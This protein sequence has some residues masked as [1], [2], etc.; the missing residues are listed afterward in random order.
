[1]T[2][3]KRPYPSQDRDS[4]VDEA[5]APAF[6]MALRSVSERKKCNDFDTNNLT[7]LPAIY[8]ET[9]PVCGNH[10]LL[11]FEARSRNF[12]K[13]QHVIALDYDV[14]GKGV[15]LGK[16]SDLLTKYKFPVTSDNRREVLVCHDMVNQNDCSKKYSDDYRFVHWAV[17]DYFCYFGPN[18]VNVPPPGWINAAHRHGVPI[19]GT[20]IARH[21]ELME[22]ALSK[23]DVIVDALVNLC[24][25]FGFEGWLINVGCIVQPK[26][27]EK[28][29][30]FLRQLRVAIK[31]EIPH[32]RIFWYD[33]VTNNGEFSLQNELNK[34]NITFHRCTGSTLIHYDWNDAS[35]ETTAATLQRERTTM[36]S[37]FFSFDINGQ[38][39]MGRIRNPAELMELI[40]D[41]CFSTAIVAPNWS[42]Q[43]S[44]GGDNGNG[45]GCE[46]AAF[47]KH[48]DHCW[49]RLWEYLGTR[50]Y[51]K[52]PFYTNFCVGSGRVSYQ[53]GFK[54]LN[55]RGSSN[56]NVQ[57]LQPS[58][59]LSGNAEYCFKE[60]FAG[61][62]S[63]RITN[64]D[65]AFRLFLTEFCLPQGVMVLGYAYKAP[66]G[67]TLDVIMRFCA[68]RGHDRDLYLFC[69]N[70]TQ[71][72]IAGGRC[73]IAPLSV[74]RA[75][76]FEH[77]EIPGVESAVANGWRTRY[78]L[79]QFDGSMILK[80]IG[81]K[82]CRTM[83]DKADT[84]LG[85]IYLQSFDLLVTK[86]VEGKANVKAYKDQL[87]TH[88]D[89]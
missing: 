26:R 72:T 1:M 78:F 69:G 9:D 55:S 85:A 11:S 52:M 18:Y 74:A 82:C 79:V 67:A 17:I 65:H 21:S 12:N 53:H 39:P 75:R 56:L 77:S 64:Y 47:L 54:L 22:E 51:C 14:R 34:R 10:Q 63:L 16:H 24:K 50:P 15:F 33:S 89:A 36:V 38:L 70:Y 88:T 32:G 76:K 57:S 28:L 37:A 66:D 61:G 35:L 40:E 4:S 23:V 60:V 45:S 87:W 19:F 81:V 48:N 83:P 59:P 71:H 13:E 49:W 7:P 84:I 68:S 73:N 86:G 46:S 41:G 31:R 80:E 42:F 29:L 30:C 43:L 20:F 5:T 25:N 8:L 62:N 6:K 44:Q 3:A 58:V 27:V 2:S